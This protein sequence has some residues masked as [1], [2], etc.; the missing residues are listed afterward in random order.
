MTKV[1]LAVD[2][3]ALAVRAAQR[4]IS[5]LDATSEVIVLGVVRHVSTAAADAS[6]LAGVTPMPMTVVDES[7]DR[8]ERAAHEDVQDVIETLGL[9]GKARAMVE[10]GEPGAT[11][12]RVAA[13]EGADV[14]VV[15]SH[16]RG[17]VGRALVGSVSNH[18]L[19]HATCP[20]LVVRERPSS[21]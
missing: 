14:V 21:N 17:I 10:R 12:C 18:V 5:I 8:A 3:S 15:G 16:G 9:V 13:R 11:I 2:G 7:N 6:G 19:H 20:V 4:A 1:L